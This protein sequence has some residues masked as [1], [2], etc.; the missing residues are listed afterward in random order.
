VI[1]TALTGFQ[2]AC[3][4]RRPASRVALREKRKPPKCPGFHVYDPIL[5]KLALSP[6][7]VEGSSR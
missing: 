4:L 2:L 1:G 7:M 3:P 5:S 6:F